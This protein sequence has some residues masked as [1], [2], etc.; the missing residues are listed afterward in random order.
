MNSFTA[1]PLEVVAEFE[2]QT[3]G[4]KWEVEFV[5]RDKL[6]AK[7]AEAHAAGVPLA[8][9]HTLR[10]IWADGGTLYD[11]RDNGLIGFE[12]QEES[13]QSQVG[14]AIEKQRG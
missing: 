13:L 14:K 8:T 3:G 4:D 2:R 11:H 7:E 10:R 5:S 9:A 1:T 12:G 6:V